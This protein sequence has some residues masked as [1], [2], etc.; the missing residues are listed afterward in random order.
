LGAHL[1]LP[2]HPYKGEAPAAGVQAGGEAVPTGAPD[3]ELLSALQALG[4]GMKL[5]WHGHSCY[6]V[7]TRGGHRLLVDPFFPPGL[8]PRRATNVSPDLVL[9]S[10]AHDDHLGS[11]VELGAPV[12]GSY[13][14][15]TYLARK[16]LR[17]TTG[18]NIGGS[19][20][21]LEGVRIWMTPATHSSGFEH[22]EGAF[23]YGG[24]ANGWMIDDGETRF[25]HAGDTGL[26]GDMRTVIRDVLKPDVAAV[27]IGDL[28]TM[29]PEH[30]A[31]AV[32]WLGV[33]TVVPM[34]FIPKPGTP[35]A[36]RY[37]EAHGKEWPSYF[38]PITID[39]AEFVSHVGQKATVVMPLPGETVEVAGRR[40]TSA[41]AAARRG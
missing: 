14:V 12:L 40:V 1:T 29:G 28:F 4:A 5:T 18:M 8:S 33:G 6:E 13:E 3:P 39:P 17:E 16:G 31:V 38:P 20:R 11:A 37:R 9:L 2:R 26:F 27:P 21:G 34:H 41:P 25:Y 36:A 7:E 19:Y 23:G 32:D 35:L 24:L 30:A 10:H 22:E 15:A